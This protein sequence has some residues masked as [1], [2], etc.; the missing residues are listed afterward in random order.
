MNETFSL[1]KL[2]IR[3]LIVIPLIYVTVG[4]CA[5]LNYARK[6]A[7]FGP[8]PDIPVVVKTHLLGLSLEDLFN[9]NA[10]IMVVPPKTRV[11][12]DSTYFRITGYFEVPGTWKF[13]VA[14]YGDGFGPKRA[15]VL[16]GSICRAI[17]HDVNNINRNLGS[18]SVE[19]LNDFLM[20]TG[21]YGSR[22][23]Y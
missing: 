20:R 11:D 16:T 12:R 5:G 21:R 3:V 22:T 13:D 19:E 23:L 1:K 8:Y 9:S 6:S 4:W 18:L 10:L 14:S 7:V 15:F 2:F 17:C